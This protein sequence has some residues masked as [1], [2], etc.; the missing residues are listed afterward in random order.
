MAAMID[1]HDNGNGPALP[2][3]ILHDVFQGIALAWAMF[4]VWATSTALFNHLKRKLTRKAKR[5]D[6]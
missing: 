1:Q 4:R 2:S 3:T 6:D 5:S